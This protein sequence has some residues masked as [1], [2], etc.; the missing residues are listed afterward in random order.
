M[1]APIIGSPSGSV[2][3]PVITLFCATTA[4]TLAA[5]T[6]CGATKGTNTTKPAAAND[7][8]LACEQPNN[9]RLRFIEAIL[10]EV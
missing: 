6:D 1:E 3:T 8:T 5:R 10:E 2:T 7:K 9:K 4:A